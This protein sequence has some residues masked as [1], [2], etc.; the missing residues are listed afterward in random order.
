[1]I[2]TF[3]SALQILTMIVGG[4]RHDSFWN[5]WTYAE[6]FTWCSSQRL[7]GTS[8]HRWAGMRLSRASRW[9]CRWPAGGWASPTPLWR[10][11]SVTPSTCGCVE[12]EVCTRARRRHLVTAPEERG[13]RQTLFSEG[14]VSESFD[15]I[16][17]KIIKN[18]HPAAQKVKNK[19]KKCLR[20]L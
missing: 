16:I 2:W 18:H 7:Y 1:M 8:P 20:C 12:L 4:M 3:A 17:D 6:T 14:L 11:C 19:N 10:G 13:Q 15:N 5:V 9:R